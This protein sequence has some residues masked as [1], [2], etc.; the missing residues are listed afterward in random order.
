[1]ASVF[2]SLLS[3]EQLAVHSVSRSDGDVDLAS[4]DAGRILFL[5][6]RA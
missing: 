6:N 5:P 2:S 3:D 1:M 4:V